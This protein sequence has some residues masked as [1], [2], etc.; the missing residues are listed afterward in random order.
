MHLA[1][2]TL[3]NLRA[4]SRLD[5]D[6]SIAGTPRRRTILLGI[7]GAGK[8]TTLDA[9]AYAFQRLQPFPETE[10]LLHPRDVRRRPEGIEPPETPVAVISLD[11]LLS[12]E[13]YAAAREKQADV[14][15]SG[16]LRFEIGAR[17][18][19]AAR[20]AELGSFSPA[21][22][23]LLVPAY[24]WWQDVFFSAALRSLKAPCV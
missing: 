14:P 24:W 5:V 18:T 16:N 9:I 21:D 2:I 12:P 11:T 1:R 6:L 22:L 23:P 20:T 19:S 13:E 3:E 17:K 4:I 10:A 7:N 8:T 15:R